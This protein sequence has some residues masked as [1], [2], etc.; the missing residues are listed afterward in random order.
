MKLRTAI[1]AYFAALSVTILPIGPSFAQTKTIR[2][3]HSHQANAESEIHT[4]A[5]IFE[6]EIGAKS[7][8]LQ[9]RIFP[10][11]A[12]GQEREVYEA[13]QLGGGATCV[14]SGTAILNNFAKRIGV[15]DLPY[16]WRDYEHVH[17]VLDGEIGATLATDLEAVGLKVLAWMDSWGYRNVVTANRDIKGP[18][19]LRGLKIRTIQTPVYLAALNAMGA[20]A[21]PM[22]Y[23][24][25]YTSL[26]TG[27]IDGME[28]G[29]SVVVSTKIFEVTK[30]MVLTRH[31]YGPLVFVCSKRAWDG[32]SEKERA[33]LFAAASTAR[34][35]QRSLAIPKENEAFAFLKGKGMTIREIDTSAFQQRAQKSQ[36][37][38]AKGLGATELLHRIRETR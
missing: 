32:Y 16:L 29:A 6:R 28:H 17:K 3:S 23:G 9:V 15:L 18:E 1:I 2:L 35:H 14:I 26:Q 37:E 12:L 11:N 19:D 5:V 21:T 13:L 30:Y 10:A 7:D 8:T 25:V 36:D 24:E 22:P 4:A 31:L 38:L 33:A 34:D 27:V 20:N